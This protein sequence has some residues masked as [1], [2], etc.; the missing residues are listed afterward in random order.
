MFIDIVK[1][2]EYAANLKPPE[3]MENLDLCPFRRI[4]RK[5]P[6]ARKDKSHR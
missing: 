4:N 5:A 6:V 2:S 3:I 1:F